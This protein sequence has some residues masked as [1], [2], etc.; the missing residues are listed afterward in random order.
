MSQIITQPTF[1]DWQK[2]FPFSYVQT[3]TDSDIGKKIYP[4][5]KPLCDATET[6][7][8]SLNSQMQGV[9]LLF[10]AWKRKSR[11]AVIHRNRS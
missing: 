9:L 2:K 10:L 5:V 6:E 3:Y 11:M 1:K 4:Q 7:L 8:R